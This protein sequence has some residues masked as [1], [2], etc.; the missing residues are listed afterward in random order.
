MFD[1]SSEANDMLC[2]E[3]FKEWHKSL[4]DHQRTHVTK[5]LT[6]CLVEGIKGMDIIA[7]SEIL[8]DFETRNDEVD[9]E[10]EVYQMYYN[11]CPF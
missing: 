9:I 11:D 6:R 10:Y 1:L 2:S 5:V 7:I 3:E 4:P 8:M